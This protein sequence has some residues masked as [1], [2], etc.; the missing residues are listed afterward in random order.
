MNDTTTTRDAD[1]L[2]AARCVREVIGGEEGREVSERVAMHFDDLRA[3]VAGADDEYDARGAVERFVEESEQSGADG[4][5]PGTWDRMQ[6][7]AESH[8]FAFV[9]NELRA[10][11]CVPDS[12][13]DEVGET[14]V[15]VVQRA[16][17]VAGAEFI[18]DRFDE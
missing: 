5:W 2:T 10:E 12:I 17:A 9:A 4:A 18:A 6:A 16:L 7:F 13:I 8:F 15:Y 1:Y 3:L 14:L 11:G